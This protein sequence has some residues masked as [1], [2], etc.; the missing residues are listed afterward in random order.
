M[1]AEFL[2]GKLE[3]R[4]EINEFG[5]EDGFLTLKKWP[6]SMAVA[7]RNKKFSGAIE[8]LHTVETVIEK[9][10]RKKDL[11]IA[12][13][14]E[15]STEEIMR[16]FVECGG[17]PFEL[18][19][20][21]GGGVEYKLDALVFGVDKEKHNFE[22]GGGE[23]LTLDRETWEKLIASAPEFVNFVLE[24]VEEFQKDTMLGE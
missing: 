6:P 3:K 8:N 19:D 16:L 14:S 2:F 18:P 5:I 17:N 9:A 11:D 23:K 15:N 10:G 12:R 7:I 4:I 20:A 22:D 1:N 13:K 21:N 24:K